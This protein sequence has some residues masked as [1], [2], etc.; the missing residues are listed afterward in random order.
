MTH[1]GEK[2]ISDSLEQHSDDI[3]M[4]VTM[5]QSH[6]ENSA[7]A[8]AHGSDEDDSSDKNDTSSRRK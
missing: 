2:H 7:A 1:L 6:L 3:Y 5:M 8:M 4:R